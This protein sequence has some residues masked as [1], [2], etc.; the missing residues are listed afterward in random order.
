MELPSN[1]RLEEE[2]GADLRYKFNIVQSDLCVSYLV[3]CAGGVSLVQ[4][5]SV[6]GNTKRDLDTR[7]ER[8]GIS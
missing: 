3:G 2:R 4:L 5:G 1:L 6:Q 7:A 8:L